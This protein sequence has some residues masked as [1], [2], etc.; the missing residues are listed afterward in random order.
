MYNLFPQ[1]LWQSIILQK[2]KR[3]RQHPLPNLVTRC[4]TKATTAHTMQHLR[5]TTA[6]VRIAANTITTVRTTNQWP[7]PTNTATNTTKVCKPIF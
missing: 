7:V 1:G 4:T 5:H 6:N 3:K 2:K